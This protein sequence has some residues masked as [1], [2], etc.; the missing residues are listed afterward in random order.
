MGK[1]QVKKVERDGHTYEID[2][3]MTTLGGNA[4]SVGRQLDAAQ[5]AA[6]YTPDRENLQGDNTMPG[7]VDEGKWDKA[8]EAVRKEHP[9]WSEDNPR[10]WKMTSAIYK[11]MGGEFS[12]EIKKSLEAIE[13]VER[14]TPTFIENPRIWVQALKKSGMSETPLENVLLT[15]RCYSEMGGRLMKSSMLELPTVQDVAGAHIAGQFE[16]GGSH[17]YLDRVVKPG[18]GYKYIYDRK[19][20]GGED[21][22]AA[23]RPAVKKPVPGAAAPAKPSKPAAPAFARE[24]EKLAQK[25]ARAQRQSLQNVSYENLQGLHAHAKGPL[26]K[27]ISEVMADR[28]R[29]G[30]KAHSDAKEKPPIQKSQTLESFVQEHY[31]EVRKSLAEANPAWDRATLKSR[32]EAQLRQLYKQRG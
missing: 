30:V 8:K 16:K 21:H 23:S 12:H 15:L 10:F 26:L 9:E 6:L 2:P 22:S 27:L 14:V 17:M 29:E 25:D 4:E 20:S 19:Q 18:G 5:K 3:V 1:Y 7:K 24:V 31:T 11:K 28:K 13:Q 32:T